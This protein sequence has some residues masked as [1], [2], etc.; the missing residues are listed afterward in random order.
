VRE[1]NELVNVLRNIDKAL[2]RVEGWLIIIFLWL[3]IILTFLQVILRS[4]YTHAHIQWANVILGQVDWF[5]PLARLSVLWITFLGASLLTGDKKH[6]KID[7]LTALLP[8][9]WQ[10][11]RGL[12]LSIVC[13]LISALML[14]ASIDYIKM[15]MA[16]GGYLF[17]KLSTWVSQLILPAGFSMILFRFFLRGIEHALEIFRSGRT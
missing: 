16:F 14:K 5:D 1:A 17:L 4:L 13:V 11:F 3:M 15:E 6:I 10:P 8:P 9:K 12:I 2:A 7:L